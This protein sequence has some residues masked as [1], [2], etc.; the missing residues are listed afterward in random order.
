MTNNIE[1]LMELMPKGY[2]EQCYATKVVVRS[3]IIKNSKDLMTL[4]L[5]HLTQ[6]S[7]LM[8]I[9]KYAGLSNIGKIRVVAFM[10]RF[11]GCRA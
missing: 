8:E 3:R 2:E 6:A 5:I 9:S 1:Q 4:C 11:A 7:S 10:K